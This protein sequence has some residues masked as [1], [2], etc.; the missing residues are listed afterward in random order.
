MTTAPANSIDGL[1]MTLAEVPRASEI[2]AAMWAAF[3]AAGC[4]VRLNHGQLTL[5]ALPG[6]VVVTETPETLLFAWAVEIAK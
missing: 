2:A 6:V 1:R 4:E 5:S 3:E